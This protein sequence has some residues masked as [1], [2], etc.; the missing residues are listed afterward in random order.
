MTKKTIVKSR[1][2]EVKLLVSIQVNFKGD[3][4]YIRSIYI[5]PIGCLQ[6]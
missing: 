2:E 6:D 3:I 5:T 1:Q 4:F